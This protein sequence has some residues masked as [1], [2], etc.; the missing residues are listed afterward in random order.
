MILFACLPLLLP[1]LPL[2]VV[3]ERV[4]LATLS[5]AA[6]KESPRLG[7]ARARAA[8]Q[9]LAAEL[10]QPSPFPTARIGGRLWPAE[11]RI[12]AA[13]QSESRYRLYTQLRLPL[14][15]VA[16]HHAGRSII[17]AADGQSAAE[18]RLA[19][20]LLLRDLSVA[21]AVE[22]AAEEALPAY[23]ALGEIEQ[24]AL[25]VAQARLREGAGTLAEVTRG[26]EAVEETAAARDELERARSSAA[27]R[28]SALTGR[29]VRHATLAPIPIGPLPDRAE[30]AARRAR[31]QRAEV[32]VHRTEST[33]HEAESRLYWRR[34]FD[35]D[36]GVGYSY[37][38]TGALDE[39]NGVSTLVE[40]GG[41]LDQPF[42][43]YR[44]RERDLYF[45]RAAALD[46]ADVSEQVAAEARAA[47]DAYRRATDEVRVD[48]ARL[49]SARDELAMTSARGGVVSPTENL[50]EMPRLI[51]AE[52]ALRRAEVQLA[53]ARGQ[54]ELAYV[55][56]LAAE[57]AEVG[58]AEAAESGAAPRHGAR[59]PPSRARGM[60]VWRTA[61]ILD[62]DP[63][64]E[65]L[66]R[67]CAQNGVT[68]I[69]LSASRGALGDRRLPSL[70]EALAEDHLR[71]EALIGEATWYRAGDRHRL[72]ERIDAIAA[73]DAEHPRSRFA[74]VH[75][76]VEP[77]QL[78]ENKGDGNLGF[79]R[80][81]IATYAA[82]HARAE[83]V[84]L[85]LAADV[86]RKLLGVSPA[87]ADALLGACPRL[88]LMLYGL[89][90]SPS[91]AK[92]I[93]ERARTALGWVARRGAGEI[94]IGVRVRDHADP[95]AVASEV[96]AALE[97][98]PGYRGAAMHDYAALR[99]PGGR[100]GNQGKADG[101]EHERGGW[102]VGGGGL[103][104]AQAGAA[105]G[106]VSLALDGGA[107]GLLPRGGGGAGLRRALA[108]DEDRLRPRDRL[109]RA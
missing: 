27:A 51:A 17:A 30:E 57:G 50:L 69:Y 68:E 102:W 10:E 54:A 28:L 18:Q 80:E 84:G 63:R 75:L 94:L 95:G 9:L 58:A 33:R 98:A 24:R 65:E 66:R 78:P 6:V 52:V 1:S 2:E 73:F 71:V 32:A 26:Q 81:L 35:L 55:N 106:Q 88:T 43:A 49:A 59:L 67:V 4:D 61:E 86:P 39:L 47:H 13:G 25:A 77:H 7:A 56:L 93:V 104:L 101:R 109:R 14:L 103:R 8:A 89:P 5:R 74:G 108:G 100:K 62:H 107:G 22:R 34:L 53:C 45:A 16:A 85:A 70:L 23:E 19:R 20:A 79:V 76:D 44:E 96:D 97:G 60:W 48:E 15:I 42:R 83:R 29:D 64:G 46:A 37:G 11:T 90:R 12:T 87:E 38:N 31:A 40:I 91:A 105:A 99:A 82:A 36:L 21:Y 92:A 72:L 41:P 3:G